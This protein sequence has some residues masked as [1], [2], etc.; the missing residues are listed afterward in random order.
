MTYTITQLKDSVARNLVG[1]SI[2]RIGDFYDIAYEAGLALQG[3]ADLKETMQTVDLV[4]SIFDGLSTYPA[5]E[6]FKSAIDIRPTSGRV[7]GEEYK[8]DY[9]RMSSREADR[10]AGYDA[11]VISEKW[12]RGQRYLVIKKYPGGGSVTTIHN[13]DSATE[14][15]TFSRSG[16][17]ATISEDTV[18]YVEGDGSLKLAV[19][20]ATGTGYIQATDLTTIDLTDIAAVYPLFLAVKYSNVSL[21]NARAITVALRIGNDLTAN[22]YDI[23]GVIHES[24]EEGTDHYIIYRFDWGSATGTVD[25]T[26]IDAMRITFASLAENM[27]INVDHLVALQPVSVT[28]DFY[29]NY[30]FNDHTT[31]EPKERPEHDDDVI[32]L[33]QESFKILSD[34]TTYLA[35]DNISGLEKKQEAIGKRLGYPTDERMTGSIWGYKRKYPSE[36]LTQR[37]VTAD[38]SV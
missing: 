7:V 13:L 14:E 28:M 15:G 5:P 27:T 35:M 1:R 8:D 19:T 10:R 24:I 16:D 12:D 3:E 11:P 2:S 37:H 20:Y 22:Y 4:P 32:I 36:K 23:T 9:T 29:S 17:I 21:V 30:L 26:A 33:G 6:G 18:S 25:L 31:G 38:W 34:L